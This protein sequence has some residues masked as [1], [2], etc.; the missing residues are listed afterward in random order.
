VIGSEGGRLRASHRAAVLG[1]VRHVALMVVVPLATG[2]EHHVSHEGDGTGSRSFRQRKEKGNR[3]VR[4][5][6]FRQRKEK[7][8]RSVRLRVRRIISSGFRYSEFTHRSLILN[9]F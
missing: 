8:N 9:G 1:P 2:M 5:R 4:L 7:V 3:S 6:S